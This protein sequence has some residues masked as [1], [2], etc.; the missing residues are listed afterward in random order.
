MTDN[1]REQLEQW[2]NDNYKQYATGWTWQRSEGNSFDCF[3]DGCTHAYS[4]AAYDI[5]CILGMELEEPE[6]DEESEW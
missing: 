5:G 6:W 4:W 1:I 2:V 3:D